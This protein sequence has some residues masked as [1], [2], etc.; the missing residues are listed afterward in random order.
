VSIGVQSGPG[1]GVQKGPTP[2]Q[3]SRG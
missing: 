1:I 3:G 2:G